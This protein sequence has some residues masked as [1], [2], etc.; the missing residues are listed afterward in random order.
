MKINEACCSAC[1][2]DAARTYPEWIEE[3]DWYP[4]YMIRK[5]R[6]CPDPRLKKRYEKALKEFNA[7]QNILQGIVNN[8]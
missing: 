4:V 5:D 3:D 1:V 7:V 8:A 6:E 2:S